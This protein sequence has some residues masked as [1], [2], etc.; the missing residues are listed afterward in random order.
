MYSPDIMHSLWNTLCV[1]VCVCI[2]TQQTFNLMINHIMRKHTTAKNRRWFMSVRLSGEELLKTWN[3]PENIKHLAHWQ[4]LRALFYRGRYWAAFISALHVHTTFMSSYFWA[5]MCIQ[6]ICWAIS[7][8]FMLFMHIRHAIDALCIY[9]H[10][11]WC[12]IN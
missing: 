2:E 9:H 6:L 3:E 5:V 11:K 1:C 8:F 4:K 7:P 10:T 12:L